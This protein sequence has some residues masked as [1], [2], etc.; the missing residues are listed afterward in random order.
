MERV[1]KLPGGKDHRLATA[2]TC[3]LPVLY[4]GELTPLS[5]P[6]PRGLRRA[7]W[8]IVKGGVPLDKRCSLE[9][10]FVSHADHDHGNFMAEQLLK[11]R[12]RL[13]IKKGQDAV[14]CLMSSS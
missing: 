14:N 11:S 4:G 8:N 13:R 5:R 10:L 2:G 7:V 1:G 12:K 9:L 3:A 6:Q